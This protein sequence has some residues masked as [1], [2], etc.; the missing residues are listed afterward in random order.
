M[1]EGEQTNPP[2]KSVSIQLPSRDD[3]FLF[4]IPAPS[5]QSV[6]TARTVDRRFS[7][8]GLPPWI[9][10]PRASGSPSRNDSQTH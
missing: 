3:G 8:R 5:S 7:F 2:T 9:H 4:S 10:G 6:R 1:A